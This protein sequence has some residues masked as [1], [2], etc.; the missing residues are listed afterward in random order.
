[1]GLITLVFIMAINWPSAVIIIPC[2]ILYFYYFKT[3]R[4]VTPALKKLDL[5]FKGP[6]V[7]QSNETMRSLPL[8]R[9]MN[10]EGVFSRVFREKVDNNVT[11]QFPNAVCGRWLTYRMTIMGAII[12]AAVCLSSIIFEGM[13]PFLT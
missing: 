10:F 4:V 2:L 12:S 7:S 6:I 1:M 13:I 11:A 8:I 3:F 5:V 9:C